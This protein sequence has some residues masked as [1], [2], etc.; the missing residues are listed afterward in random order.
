VL[1]VFLL[2]G[3]VW[4]YVKLDTRDSFYEP[5]A[6]SS[7][8]QAAIDANLAAEAA[9]SAALAARAQALADLELKRER[10]RTALDAEQPAAELETAYRDAERSFAQA[11]KSVTAAQAR[12]AETAPAASA[13]S[14]RRLDALQ[15]KQRRDER[16][17]FFLRLAFALGV[18]GAAY[19]LLHVLRGSRYLPLGIAAVGAAAI[20]SLVFAGDYVEDR[21]ELRD[22]GP[23]V[24]SLAGIALTLGAFWGLQRYLQRRIPLRR[25]RKGECPFCGFPTAGNTSC[26]GCG[27]AVAGACSHCG[28]RRRVGVAFCGS[29]GKA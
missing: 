11:E 27:R 26:E 8:D 1:G 14:E 5:P 3:L 24:L 12:V 20:L 21:V 28:E 2:V 13:A 7:A 4:G 18:L 22:S 6:L 25:V 29:C 16:L 10:Y 15:A 23:V 9:L 19:G 17:T